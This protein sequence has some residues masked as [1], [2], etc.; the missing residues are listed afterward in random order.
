MIPFF[1]T[2]NH[3]TMRV[4]VTGGLTTSPPSASERRRAADDIEFVAR[5]LCMQGY[6]TFLCDMRG[7]LGVLAV[8]VILKI[9][10]PFGD[11]S[12]KQIRRV[13]NL[14]ET[15][16][17]ASV[18]WGCLPESQEPGILTIDI[19]PGHR[20]N[21]GCPWY[22]REVLD[23]HP[24]KYTASIV[25]RWRF[26]HSYRISPDET[27]WVRDCDFW[28]ERYIWRFR[29][30]Q[31][32]WITDN[33]RHPKGYGCTYRF[34]SNTGRLAVHRESYRIVSLTPEEMVWLNWSEECEEFGMP[35]MTVLRRSHSG[36]RGI[37]KT[38]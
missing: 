29:K 13:W 21:N 4:L 33:P 8:A 25:G 31:M 38:E 6:E 1:D 14:A 28:D 23:N 30:N 11:K 35:Y 18:V 27:E 24:E 12:P 26:S 19:A 9:N 17:S 22:M 34:D 7:W 10:I 20:F 15:S 36:R 37:S 5:W 3:P 16:C 2:C 32:V